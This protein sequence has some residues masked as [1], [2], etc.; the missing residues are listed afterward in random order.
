MVKKYNKRKSNPSDDTGAEI[1]FAFVP[2][3]TK[4]KRKQYL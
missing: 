2:M 3:E 4:P 1:A